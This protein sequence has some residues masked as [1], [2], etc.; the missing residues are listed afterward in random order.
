M[1][2]STTT[3]VLTKI[4]APQSSQQVRLQSTEPVKPLSNEQ[5]SR[6]TDS[7]GK[8]DRKHMPYASAYLY[9]G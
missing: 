7:V 9:R 2:K 5:I 4:H 8:G 6:L 1:N 3:V